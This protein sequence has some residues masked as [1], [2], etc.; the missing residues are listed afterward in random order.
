MSKKYDTDEDFNEFDEG[1]FQEISKI[2]REYESSQPRLSKRRQLEDLIEAR[3]LE[4]EIDDFPDHIFE[5]DW[6]QKCWDILY[7]LYFDA[8]SHVFV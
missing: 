2:E 3:R 1:T 8:D 4:E 7:L 5:I 6:Q